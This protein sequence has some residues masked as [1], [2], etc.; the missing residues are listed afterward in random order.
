MA[1]LYIEIYIFFNGFGISN[2]GNL[3]GKLMGTL[4]MAAWYCN[5]II[6]MVIQMMLTN[7]AH[8]MESFFVMSVELNQQWPLVHPLC[9]H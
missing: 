6:S 1:V 5:A 2:P 7:V 3:F 8:A 4:V 9:H